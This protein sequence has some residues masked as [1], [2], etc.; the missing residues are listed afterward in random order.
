MIKSYSTQQQKNI[1]HVDRISLYLETD[2]LSCL[3]FLTIL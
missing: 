2:Y 1:D 3:F